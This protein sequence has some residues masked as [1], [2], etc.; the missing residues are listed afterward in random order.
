RAAERGSG[1]VV[2]LYD[3]GLPVAAV[4]VGARDAAVLSAAA[5]R[6]LSPAFHLLRV[7]LSPS[8]AGTPRPDDLAAPVADSERY[9]V[10][11]RELGHLL[12]QAPESLHASEE[13][14]SASEAAQRAEIESYRARVGEL[15][16]SRSRSEMEL[17][18]LRDLQTAYAEQTR[19]LEERSRRAAELEDELRLLEMKLE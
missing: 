15:E 16:A 13:R 14:A 19:Q 11:V 18:V 3:R 10:E 1:A 5:L 12:R 6:L 8:R 17:S 7:L 2:P 4:V 9:L